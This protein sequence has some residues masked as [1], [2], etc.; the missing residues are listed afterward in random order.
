MTLKISF[1][2]WWGWNYFDLIGIRYDWEYISPNPKM[3]EIAFCNFGLMIK[4][5]E[6]N[7]V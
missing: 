3:V 7:D 5:G 4:W 6:K 2:S 1:R